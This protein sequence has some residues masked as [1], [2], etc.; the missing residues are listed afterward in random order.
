M[1]RVVRG[2]RDGFVET[3]VHNTVLTRR[4]VRDPRLR[5]ETMKVG[6]RSKTDVC[7]A[8]I[9]DVADMGLV[10]E[11]KKRLQKIDVDGL[12]MAE[13]SV[14]EFITHALEK[15]LAKLA[16][17]KDEEE[18]KKRLRGLGYIS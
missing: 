12:A 10:E 1:E 17:A 2:S 18:I 11:I 3:L 14:E 13:K 4:R 16:D 6:K 15:E 5:M 7:V 9:E 8:Y